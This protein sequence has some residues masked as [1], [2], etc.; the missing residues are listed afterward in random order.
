MVH[1]RSRG[2]SVLAISPD[3]LAYEAAD[4]AVDHD[5]EL[6]LRLARAE[7]QLL[8]SRLNQAGVQVFNWD[9][10]VPFDRAMQRSLTRI[11]PWVQLL[12][13]RR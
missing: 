10:N 1:L 4:I 7:R 8:L 6:G 12:G 11:L 9:V 3:P 13:V 2:Y 5:G